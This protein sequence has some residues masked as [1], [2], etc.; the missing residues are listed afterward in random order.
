M[1]YQKTGHR[2]HFNHSNALPRYILA[3]DVAD[4]KEQIDVSGRLFS[5]EFLGASIVSGRLA[6]DKI[7]SKRLHS[8]DNS[9]EL[10][11]YI[12]SFTKPNY[13][14]WLVCDNALYKL[15]L[16][17]IAH[18][19]THGDLHI[20][21]PRS[22]RQREDNEES[23]VHAAALAVIESPPTII[24]CR[25][26][27]TQGRIVIV[28]YRNWFQDGIPTGAA[29]EGFGPVVSDTQA[30]T[31]GPARARCERNA[32]SLHSNFVRLIA[33]VKE[34]DLGLFRYTASSQSY[35]AYRHRFMKQQIYVHDNEPIQRMEHHAHL[36]GRS[37]VFKRGD[38]TSTCH[39]VDINA[40]YP[41]VMQAGWYPYKLIRSEIRGEFGGTL[42]KIDWSAAVAEVK[43]RTDQSLYPL[44][45]KGTIIY[46]YG[47]FYCTLA[48]PDL[49]RAF[50]SGAIMEVRSWSEYKMAMIFR[51]WV[52]ELW[53]MR[54]KYKAEDNPLYEQ[55]TKRI[56]NS[57][58]GKFGQM[59]PGWVNVPND[60]SMLPFTTER[61]RD[62]QTGEWVAYRA[63]GWQ[64]QKLEKRRIKP[65]SFYA[66]P[67]FVTSL[68][69]IKMDSLRTI[70]GRQNVFYQG[71]D[72]LIVTDDGLARL[73]VAG[74]IQPNTIGKLRVQYSANT[75]Y[76]N[77][78][79]DYM[80]GSRKILSGL[81][82]NHERDTQGEIMQH[83]LYVTDHL[84]SKGPISSV[85]E[86]IEPW[87][88]G[89]ITER[90]YCGEDGW[91]EPFTLSPDTDGAN[92]GVYVEA[93]AAVA[94]AS[95]AD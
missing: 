7:T 68:A 6:R 28:D 20:D 8:F 35:G 19:F 31:D 40:L 62:E 24:G 90:G 92:G 80:L 57:L 18:E 71:I 78:I 95:K 72:S 11:A 67:A 48:G 73:T 38:I 91:V 64:T 79:C 83:K 3:L 60:M 26:G 17:G 47:H 63:I 69:R 25:V 4:R 59:S 30:N 10:W 14:T 42:P 77:G 52:D 58:Y 81:A 53:A 74:H 65:G 43:I 36:G 41:S 23:N 5:R 12:Y 82:T 22:K 70:A 29:A 88:P 75:G 32:E 61:R 46:P 84:F 13:T 66:V 94:N 50:N 51:E 87:Q 89:E 34:N 45:W 93:A 21:K 1:E 44:R 39:L 2:I 16:S 55:F 37:T 76:I 9:D 56:M 86:K 15:V 33:W 49:Y 27:K 85:M 54:Q